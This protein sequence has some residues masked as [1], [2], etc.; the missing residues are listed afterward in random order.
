MTP[1]FQMAQACPPPMT[2]LWQRVEIFLTASSEIIP[3][4]GCFCLGLRYPCSNNSGQVTSAL[5][6]LKVECGPFQESLKALIM[7]VKPQ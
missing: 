5:S 3:L 2:G 6:H 7:R 1:S 4:T